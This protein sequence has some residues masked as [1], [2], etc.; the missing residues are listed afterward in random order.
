MCVYVWVCLQ[1]CLLTSAV[2]PLM[3]ICNNWLSTAVFDVSLD[4][5]FNRSVQLL[6]YALASAGCAAGFLFGV[7]TVKAEF[8]QLSSELD[9]LIMHVNRLF[10]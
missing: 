2:A 5:Q 1:H 4:K 3:I 7:A 10:V 9:L 8:L 6:I